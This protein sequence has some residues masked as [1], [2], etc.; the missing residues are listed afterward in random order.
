[1][2][3]FVTVNYNNSDFTIK[4]I[5]SIKKLKN[6]DEHNNKII[7]VDNAS[8]DT[9]ITK[10]N[11]Y[12]DSLDDVEIVKS[13]TNLGY[14]KGLNLGLSRIYNIKEHAG[15]VVGNNDITFNEDFLEIFAKRKYPDRTF[16]I[17]PNIVTKDGVMQNPHVIDSVGKWHKLKS[18]L[19][20]INY[21]LTKMSKMVLKIF[22][23][24][25][26]KK[27]KISIT[28]PT[29]IKRGIGACYILLPA[30]FIEYDKL[31]DSVFM[32]GEEALLSNQVEKASGF[33][34]YDPE[35]KMVHFE[36]ASVSKMP[37]KKKY[38]ITKS[39]YKKYRKYL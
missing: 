15:I 33:T 35:L 3:S 21:Y 9:D 26:K 17:A 23:R 4:Y 39:S 2:I 6:Y 10:L 34:V 30:F 16:V 5:E 28:Q 20:F 31:D 18:D 36:S 24:N 12:C 14:F 22:R 13:K 7:I 37:S 32:W 8:N 1:M 38:I 27:K 25:K 29:I 19:Y 11:D